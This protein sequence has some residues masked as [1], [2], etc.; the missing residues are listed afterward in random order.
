[1]GVVSRPRTAIVV[2]GRFQVQLSSRCKDVPKARALAR[3]NVNVGDK[4]RF[5]TM[6]LQLSL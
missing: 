4:N 5:T 1:M 6:G 2:N 3:E